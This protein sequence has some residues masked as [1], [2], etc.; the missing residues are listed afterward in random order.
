MPTR[1]LR[2]GVLAGAREF[3][4]K[5]AGLQC[6]AGRRGRHP[7]QQ[8]GAERQRDQAGLHGRIHRQDGVDAEIGE[9]SADGPDD[10]YDRGETAGEPSPRDAGLHLG[11]ALWLDH[12]G[13]LRRDFEFCQRDL[14]VRRFG[15]AEGFERIAFVLVV[16]EVHRKLPRTRSCGR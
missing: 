3:H 14:T 1:F 11:F 15:I 12:R 6:F 16:V 10:P 4:S 2:A 8:C 9:R 13:L 5:A 7:E